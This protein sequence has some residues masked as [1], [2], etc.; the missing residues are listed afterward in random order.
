MLPEVFL[1]RRIRV[2]CKRS[3]CDD[4][5]V[6]HSPAAPRRLTCH[7]APNAHGL[8]WKSVK[9]L[10]CWIL[11]RCLARFAAHLNSC[12]PAEPRD[13]HRIEGVS[14]A[15]VQPGGAGG[16]VGDAAEAE[17]E[18]AGVAALRGI[19]GGAGRALDPG[20]RRTTLCCC[21]R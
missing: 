13:R 16:A 1:E 14:A 10:L 18:A 11:L 4:T 7:T 6:R 19:G 8:K 20:G 5:Y 21:W 9:A 12:P 2:F 3:D 15:D 17:Q